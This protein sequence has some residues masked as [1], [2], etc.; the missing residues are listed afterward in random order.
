MSVSEPRPECAFVLNWMHS[1]K[2]G[3][4]VNQYRNRMIMIASVSVYKAGCS[5]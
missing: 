3:H 1:D 2:A 4:G 5:S